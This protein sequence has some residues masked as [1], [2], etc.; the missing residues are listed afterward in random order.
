MLKLQFKDR[1]REAVW[2]VDQRFTIGKLP[3]NSLMIEDGR[4]E[5]IHAELVNQNEQLT[6]FNRTGGTGVW[7]NGIPVS[8]ELTVNAGDAITLG[9]IELELI[10]PK[11]QTHLAPSE[12][13]PGNS[14][15]AIHSK[16]S[17]LEQNR[18]SIGESVTIGRD[19]SC[20]ISIPLDHLSRQ[21]LELS[22]RGGQMYARDLESSNGT[23]VN[24]ERITE[25]AVKSGDKIKL[26]VV[27]FEVIGPS[28]DPHKT[29]IRTAPAATNP[30][31]T[32]A[33]AGKAAT[34]K[35]ASKPKSTG[36][37]AKARKAPS[38]KKLVADG[39]QEWLQQEAAQPTKSKGGGAWW[40]V[41]LIVIA[42]I[43]AALVLL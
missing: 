38:K 35:A 33:S 4:L 34:A 13:K 11:Q 23:F 15:W 12:S 10:D 27:T 16:A 25:T 31:N 29:I 39:K 18:Y 28:H 20:D 40:I 41:G 3:S 43:A 36:A 14:G 6:L 24:G 26:D 42:G 37:P 22:I 17:W 1:R 21:H 5:D 19:P 8:D 7:V 30:K 32:G 9:D 2:L